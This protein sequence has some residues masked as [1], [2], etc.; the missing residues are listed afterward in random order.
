MNKFIA[1]VLVLLIVSMSLLSCQKRYLVIEEK[2]YSSSDTTLEETTLESSSE[3]T[4]TEYTTE[5]IRHYIEP[6]GESFNSYEDFEKALNGEDEKGAQKLQVLCWEV[7]NT[8]Q[9][10]NIIKQHGGAK[11]PLI[12]GELMPITSFSVYALY[13]PFG[14][15]IEYRR[16]YPDNLLIDVYV[17][18]LDE[19]YGRDFS[20]FETPKAINNELY[21][22]FNEDKWLDITININGATIAAMELKNPTRENIRQI[23]YYY[24]GLY[25]TIFVNSLDLLTDEFLQSFSIG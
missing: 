7:P 4:T 1:I 23:E 3:E 24:D 6:L 18:Y 15:F 20:I 19:M 12:N 10:L 9:L 14:P 22:D 16:T 2:S 25:V 11:M 8:E 13:H 21:N 17:H 5:E